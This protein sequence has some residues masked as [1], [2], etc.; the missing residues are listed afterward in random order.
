MKLSTEI[1]YLASI[2]MY[3]YVTNE[4]KSTDAYA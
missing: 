4:N 1:A 3:Y 2:I